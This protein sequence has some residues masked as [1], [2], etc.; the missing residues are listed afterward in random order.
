MRMQT[1]ESILTEVQ[2]PVKKRWQRI[3]TEEQRFFEKVDQNQIGTGCWFW[4]GARKTPKGYGAFWYDNKNR[5]AHQFAWEHKNGRIPDGLQ[6]LHKCD[7]TMCVNPNHLFLGTNADNVADKVA[8]GRQSKGDHRKTIHRGSSHGNAK[9]DESDV[10]EIRRYYTA[11]FKGIYIAKQFNIT[12]AAV[13]A[14][15]KRKLWKHV[16]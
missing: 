2:N 15:V 16:V 13:S 14:I 7:N 12:G 11:G 8:K 10:L 1:A 4:I 9:L 6:V 5:S 3:K